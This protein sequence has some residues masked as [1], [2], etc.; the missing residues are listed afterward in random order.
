MYMCGSAYNKF[1]DKYQERRY[2]KECGL[3]DLLVLLYGVFNS[4]EFVK[5]SPECTRTVWGSIRKPAISAG[6]GIFSTGIG[7]RAG[8]VL[9]NNLR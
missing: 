7:Q 3:G 1:A 6:N 5:S 4:A 2:V 8:L 9:S